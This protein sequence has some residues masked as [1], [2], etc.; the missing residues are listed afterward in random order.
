MGY[1]T[2]EDKNNGI[3][4]IARNVQAEEYT[5]M[6]EETQHGQRRH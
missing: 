3:T 1:L 2:I 6:S 5:C 4:T